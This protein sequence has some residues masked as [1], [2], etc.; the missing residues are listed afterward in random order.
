MSTLVANCVFDG[1]SAAQQ[2][3]GAQHGALALGALVAGGLAIFCALICVAIAVGV[4]LSR[5]AMT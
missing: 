1:R 4:A 5:K 3:Q 2:Q